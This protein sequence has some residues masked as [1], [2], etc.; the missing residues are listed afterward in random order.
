MSKN[1]HFILFLFTFSFHLLAC[2][3][4]EGDTPA[5]TITILNVSVTESNRDTTIELT[6]TLNPPSKKEVSFH[7]TTADGTAKAGEDYVAQSGRVTFAPGD[8]I[9]KITITIKGDT[10][11]EPEELFTLRLSDA[12]NGILQSNTVSIIIKNDDLFIPNEG[13]VTP[14]TYAGKTLVWSDEFDGATLDLTAWTH[15]IGNGSNGWGN[16]ELQYYRGE[17]TQ[18]TNGYLVIEAREENVQGFRYTS[19]RLITK[20]KREFKHGRIDIRAVLPETQGIWPALWTLG[21]DIDRVNWP[22]CGEIDIMELLGHEPNKI[23][24]TAHYGPDWMQHRSKGTSTL[25]PAGEKFSTKFHVFSIDWTEDNIKWYLDDRLFF[26]F[27]KSDVGTFD[28]PF[29]KPHY[30]LFNVAV[31]GNWP[32]SPN[33]STVFPQQMI[34]DYV[35]VFQ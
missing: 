20:G 32:G 14:K 11:K 19:S 30:L 24:G 1:I 3:K 23:H 4:G 2:D 10:I 29:N 21:G 6:A 5:A 17:N 31:G 7:F 35:R 18:L 22:A 33:T 26:E 27:K 16:N 13:Y 15:Q 9:K 12:V 25:L 28:Y 8:N 34:V